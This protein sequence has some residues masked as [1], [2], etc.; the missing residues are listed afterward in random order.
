MILRVVYKKIII[1]VINIDIN[2]SMNSK[3]KIFSVSLENLSKCKKSKIIIIIR[4][5]KLRSDI[6]YN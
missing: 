6:Y 2:N 5:K 3:K 1:V 4:V